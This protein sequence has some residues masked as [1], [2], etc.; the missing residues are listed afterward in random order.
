MAGKVR[1]SKEGGVARIIFD[2]PERRNAISVDMWCQ[3]P[4]VA[5]Q[6]ADDAEVRVVILRGAGE[7]AFVA[8]A[9][10]SEFT[11]Q[12]VG[13]ATESYDAASARAF[14]ALARLRMPVIAQ[15]YGACIGGGVAMALAADVRY[16]ADD[17]FF[18]IPAARL[19]LGYQMGGI[20][21]LAA[22][23]GHSAAKE[24]FFTARRYSATEAHQ[25][26]LFNRVAP[27]AE[28]E[29]LV[30][31]TAQRIAENAPLTLASIKRISFE[32][33][34]EPDARDIDAVTASIAACFESEDYREGIQAFLEKRRT[35]F[36]GR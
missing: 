26:G 27:A 2:H 35:D 20:E 34:K 19:G 8:G 30:C 21:A 1:C 25:L 32:L 23:V 10:I 31:E 3:I 29:S 11:A 24:I 18:A 22:V 7:T 33:S 13:A 4:E 36:R 6:L 28:L 14:G 5:K 15:I 12:R 16:A 17:A 9:D